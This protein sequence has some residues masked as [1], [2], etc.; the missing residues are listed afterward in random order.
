M[1]CPRAVGLQLLELLFYCHCAEWD[2]GDARDF[3]KC[4]RLW[5]LCAIIQYVCVFSVL[6]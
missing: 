2:S 3:T 6:S 5:V 4:D 1:S